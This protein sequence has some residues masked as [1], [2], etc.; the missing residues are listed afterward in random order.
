MRNKL[1]RQAAAALLALAVTAGAAPAFPSAGVS[2]FPAAVTASA[3]DFTLTV[4]N[5]TLTL[6]GDMQDIDAL[7]AELRGLDWSQITAVK[8]AAG[9]VFPESC[10]GLFAGN[11]SI[12]TVDFS[13]ADFSHVKTAEDLLVSC[14]N[15]ET[16]KMTGLDLSALENARDMFCS[17]RTLK[18]VDLT[19]SVMTKVKEADYMFANDNALEEVKGLAINSPDLKTVSQL[20]Y[21]CHA[22]KSIDLSQF[23]TDSVENFFSMFF[24]CTALTELDLSGFRT[25]NCKNFESMFSYCTSLR[26]LDLRSFDTSNA[27]YMDYMFKSCNSLRS[28]D[29]SSFNTAKV[30]DIS[31]MFAYCPRLKTAD[32]SSFSFDEN[33]DAAYLFSECTDLTE[34]DLSGFDSSKM[35][36]TRR[37]FEGLM[38]LKKLTLGEHFTELTA[39]MNL[40]EPAFGWANETDPATVVSVPTSDST[41]YTTLSNSGKNTYISR[42][43]YGEITDVQLMLLKDGSTS[44]RFYAELSDLMDEQDRELGEVMFFV[45]NVAGGASDH[46]IAQKDENGRYY[47]TVNVPP[48]CMTS[49]IEAD[50]YFYSRQIHNLPEG[51]EPP[52]GVW[53][54]EF[55]RVYY[56]IRNYADTLL[57]DPE[58]YAAEQ[59]LIKAMLCYGGAVQRHFNYNYDAD[60]PFNY[61]AADLGIDYSGR[62][63]TAANSFVK[64]QPI[65]G[66]SYAGSSVVLGS[67]TKQRHYF[68]PEG[69]NISDFSFTVKKGGTTFDAEP[70]LF[71]N[72]SGD[73]YFIETEGASAMNL[74]DALT[75]TAARKTDASQKMQ[76]RY[77]AMDYVRLGLQNGRLTGTAAEVAK[78]LGWFAAEAKDFQN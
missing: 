47:A 61:P 35:T 14:S 19:G 50:L 17:C 70:V 56:S 30:K 34:I 73:L 53:S 25:G 69:S 57:D 75:I 6:A 16:V 66:L 28:V 22:L 43:G 72:E 64:P 77:S 37:M 32:L 65:N 63:F 31:S 49:K 13:G 59:D 20:F 48:K 42:G 54:K 8:A 26:T 71:S 36:R 46:Y 23:H 51:Q 29:V 2:L 78:T 33:V 9:A 58:T 67:T 27:E 68:K 76:F 24:G 74:Y 38:H 39:E 21:Y 11:S 15:L 4:A 55:D 62:E 3:A 5:G 1:V 44:V 45:Y 18:S 60:Q 40:P 12:V 41:P 52:Q 10:S 7:R